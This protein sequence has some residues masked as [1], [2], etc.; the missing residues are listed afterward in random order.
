MRDASDQQTLCL[1]PSVR[2][3]WYKEDP[4]RPCRMGNGNK[5]LG[6]GEKKMKI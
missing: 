1:Q 5:H 3:G 6:R 2:L 4:Q